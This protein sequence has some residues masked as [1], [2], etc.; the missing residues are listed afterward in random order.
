[1]LNVPP[2][3]PTLRD[4]VWA[5]LKQ[6][7]QP[8]DWFTLDERVVGHYAWKSAV[9]DAVL[10]KQGPTLAGPITFLEI[11]VRCGYSLQAFAV[12]AS[13]HFVELDALLVDAYL[14][15]DSPA[16]REWFVTRNDSGPGIAAARLVV[17]NTRHL[18]ALP[19][20]AFA[21]VDGEHT[22]TGVLRDLRLVAG[23]RT[24]LV[25]DCDNPQVM[26]GV[27]EWL[28][29]TPGRDCQFIDDGLRTLGV[30]SRRILP[31]ISG[32]KG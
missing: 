1:M 32:P 25:D 22:D 28:R 17:A 5:R 14:D 11:G 10:E 15:A 20:A 12:A 2:P 7:W 18:L 24:I 19:A 23:C 3:S 6:R 4:N 27:R 30:I 29:D 13:R 31:E 16:C 8:Q 26:K 9:L 21:H